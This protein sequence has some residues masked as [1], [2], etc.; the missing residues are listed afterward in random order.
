MK[1]Y[2]IFTTIFLFLFFASVVFAQK[3]AAPNK[4]KPTD[5]E[6]KQLVKQLTDDM[7]STYQSA[8]ELTSKGDKVLFLP[9]NKVGDPAAAQPLYTR[10]NELLS[11]FFDR[12]GELYRQEPSL[13]AELDVL[14]AQNARGLAWVALAYGDKDQHAKYRQETVDIAQA[15][16]NAIKS[17]TIKD[18]QFDWA[19]ET[20]QRYLSE[21]HFFLYIHYKSMNDS[22]KAKEHLKLAIATTSDQKLK[23]MYN[24]MLKKEK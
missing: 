14:R 10:S 15:A 18:V 3:S 9:D 7:Q 1:K 20:L 23:A 24:D 8:S 17:S 6:I 19:K 13:F 2:L 11:K 16:L 22:A 21:A 12:W 5:E 4:D